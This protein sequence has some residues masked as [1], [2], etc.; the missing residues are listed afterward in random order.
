MLAEVRENAIAACGSGLDSWMQQ[1]PE[2]GLVA[3]HGGVELAHAQNMR[4]PASVGL[5][6]NAVD[7]SPGRM[8]HTAAM[9]KGAD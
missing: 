3:T 1:E 9:H 4:R 8:L 5:L 6:R 7:R 2:A